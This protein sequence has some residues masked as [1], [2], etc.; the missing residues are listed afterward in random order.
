MPTP[1]ST[2]IGVEP[3]IQPP[4]YADTVALK[5][6]FRHLDRAGRA[7]PKKFRIS[8]N[9]PDSLTKWLLSESRHQPTYAISRRERSS[10]NKPD[11][12]LHDGISL[13]DPTY[14]SFRTVEASPRTWKVRLPPSDAEP[15]VSLETVS[16]G[17]D[18]RAHKRPVIKFSVIT[19]V[20]GN[21]ENF[22]WRSSNND[23]I[24]ALLGGQSLGWKL[25]RI[26]QDTSTD[27][28]PAPPGAWPRT[29]NG[30]EIVAVFSSS[31]PESRSAWQFSFIGNGANSILG[32]QWEVMA[33]TTSLIIM[34]CSV[35]LLCET[36]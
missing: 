23:N 9:G 26:T 24:S 14:S 1:N 5:A 3:E 22:E 27:R 20:S 11:V 34:D 12:V 4:S 7:F 32:E 29:K 36:G 30:A 15:E 21:R 17:S 31:G 18:W 13:K 19:D 10:G 28:I 25:V 35:R 8:P 16:A 33:V 6:A 2:K